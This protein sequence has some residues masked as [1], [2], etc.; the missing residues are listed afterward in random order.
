MVKNSKFIHYTDMVLKPRKDITQIEYYKAMTEKSVTLADFKRKFNDISDK[1]DTDI[2]FNAYI[3]K[4]ITSKNPQSGD[5]EVLK[6]LAITQ[7]QEI[8]CIDFW[9]R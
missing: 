3:L 8:V 7:D 5:L 9:D 4:V 2:T 6:V 1:K